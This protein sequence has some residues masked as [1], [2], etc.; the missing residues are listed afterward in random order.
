MA[1]CFHFCAKLPAHWYWIVAAVKDDWHWHRVRSGWFGKPSF[2]AA[3]IT[4]TLASVLIRAR[5]ADPS[6]SLSI[7]GI[8]LRF[9][10][11]ANINLG[12]RSILRHLLLRTSLI[13][14][15][16][17]Y[18]IKWTVRNDRFFRNFSTFF[19]LS[20][21]SVRHA[22]ARDHRRGISLLRQEC[23]SSSKSWRS[24]AVVHFCAKASSGSIIYGHRIRHLDLH[25]SDVGF[26]QILKTFNLNQKI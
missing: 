26:F 22:G 5:S 18:R 13:R 20:G 8:F 17:V 3:F 24:A 9:A 7:L 4:L 11:I 12:Y 23:C 16:G 19:C 6:I 14:W 10:A 25:F 2:V 1:I 15:L 21:I